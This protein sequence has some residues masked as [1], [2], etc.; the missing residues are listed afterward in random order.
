MGA[1]ERRRDCPATPTQAAPVLTVPCSLHPPPPTPHAGP[2]TCRR[3][4]TAWCVL[5]RLC[6]EELS[7][8]ISTVC[9][10]PAAHSGLTATCNP[11]R[12]SLPTHSAQPQRQL[13]LPSRGPGGPCS[14]AWVSPSHI[15]LYEKDPPANREWLVGNV[16]PGKILFPWSLDPQ[17]PLSS[18]VTLCPPH[19]GQPTPGP[20]LQPTL[21]MPGHPTAGSGFQM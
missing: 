16:G 4:M 21:G 11:G 10:G 19:C 5:H 13:H 18:H 8:W 12:A 20:P 9:M 17:H 2:R 14:Q 3:P 7:T 15:N 6:R 1:E